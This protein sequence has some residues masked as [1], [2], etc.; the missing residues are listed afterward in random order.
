MRLTNDDVLLL[1]AYLDGELD[2]TTS[3]SMESK[4][5]EDAT[6]QHMARE[7][8]NLKSALS[9][10][11][12]ERDVS[13]AFMSRMEGKLGIERR[14]RPPQWALLA[15]SL[16]I[17]V[18]AS[19]SLT[20]IAVLQREPLSSSAQLLDG[21]L[22]ALMSSNQTDVSSSYRHT[23]KPWF[24][25]RITQ[26]PRVADLTGQGFELLGARIDVIASTPVPTLV[27]RRRQHIIS[28]SEILLDDTKKSDIQE[29]SE[30]GYNIVTW[31]EGPRSFVAISDLNSTELVSFARSVRDSS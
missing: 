12:T 2:V 7:V 5:R 24:N 13:E 17:V 1:H 16:M 19:V 26:A 30:H 9:R 3:L 6:L 14:W 15:A 27:Y 31:T 8:T 18:G 20:S 11:H 21:H 10:L 23:V 4:I 25:G 28:L 22:R 29:R